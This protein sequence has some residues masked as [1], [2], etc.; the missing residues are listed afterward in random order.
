MDRDRVGSYRTDCYWA[1]QPPSMKRALPV[2]NADASEARKTAAPA[3]SRNSPHRP[4][5]ILSTNAWYFAGSL[6]SCL[7]ISVA[8]GPGQMALTVTPFAAHSNASTRVRLSSPALE[9]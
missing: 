5:G 2:T 1:V 7:F 3:I 8:N 6:R 9:E 4:M